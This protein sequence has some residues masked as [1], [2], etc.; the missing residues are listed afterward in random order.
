MPLLTICEPPNRDYHSVSR[1]PKRECKLSY[2]PIIEMGYVRLIYLKPGK[3]E[4][5]IHISYYRTSL[6][7]KGIP[8][9]ALSYVWGKPEP[10]KYINV[11]TQTIVRWITV[12]PNLEA[13]LRQLRHSRK[14]KTYWVDALCIDQE[15]GSAEKQMQIE[16]MGEIYS[17][18]ENV[19]VWLGPASQD[20]TR[21]MNFIKEIS[22]LSKLD[23]LV[24]DGSYCD[25][26][27]ALG[28]LIRRPWFSRRWV[29]QELSLAKAAMV[30]CGP[31]MVSWRDFADAVAIFETKSPEIHKLFN[32]DSYTIGEIQGLGAHSLI[33]ASQ[34]L[35]AQSREGKSKQ[36]L[37]TLEYLVSYLSAFDVSNP[38]DTVYS[39]LS[40]AKNTQGDRKFIVDYRQSLNKVLK[41][42]IHITI[43]DSGSLD[44]LCR[45][46]AP[47]PTQLREWFD[48]PIPYSGTDQRGLRLPSWI[49]DTTENE[50]GPRS[51]KVGV[52]YDRLNAKKFVGRPGSPI[53]NTSAMLK[54][55]IGTTRFIQEKDPEYLGGMAE[56]LILEG[57]KLEGILSDD[58]GGY[59]YRGNVPPDWPRLGSWKDHTASEVPEIFWRTLVADRGLDGGKPPI[60]YRR[61][62]EHA[63]ADTSNPGLDTERIL[64]NCESSMTAEFLTRVQQTI[65]N[66]QMF[67]TKNERLLGLGPSNPSSPYTIKGGDTICI[68]V[69]SSVPVILR[70][71]LETGQYIFIGE[72]Y[73]HGIMDGE[74]MA[75][76][77][78]EK[79]RFQ[80]IFLR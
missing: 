78:K 67:V 63:W 60:W 4:D 7:S 61:A 49:R 68:L 79:M 18:A 22:D 48:P 6:K 11:D 55:P 28:A 72:C 56:I 52:Q 15:D 17:N 14:G 65:W 42:V 46:W 19:I 9:E 57:F 1:D 75:A 45:P 54:V 20:S 35:F 51:N 40:L 64:R 24:K 76:F 26:W 16:Q 59:A 13:A 29:V 58:I 21:G 31:E 73:I 12:T 2:K 47:S 53:Y 50:F 44:I 10:V 39:L 66:R 69:G 80:S 34:N 62:C 71:H 3:W 43:K 27:N 77:Q 38:W 25:S 23:R 32:N 74:A 30:Y 37:V 5:E 36:S 41:H 70:P 33:T 8:Y